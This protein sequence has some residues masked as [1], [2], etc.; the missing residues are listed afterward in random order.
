MNH[1]TSTAATST[2][3]ER[4]VPRE[5]FPS[6]SIAG[7]P[8]CTVASPARRRAVPYA[9]PGLVVALGAGAL[10]WHGPIAQTAHYHEF[11][12][13]RTL[14]GIAHAA[15]VLSN[16]GFALVGI[17]GLQRLRAHGSSPV[18]QAGR[19]G[20]LVFFLALL[21]TS[22]GS[23]FYHLAPD[24]A[25]LVW[26]RLPIAMA[27]AGLLAACWRET[28]GAGRWVTPALVALALASVAWWR[29]TDLQ[30]AG[31]LRPYLLLQFLPMVLLPL[32]QWQH[33]AP[34]AERLATGGAMALYLLAKL[35]ELA[36]HAIFHG[37]V[38]ISGHTI[39]HLLA[40]LAAA[41]LAGALG[42]RLERAASQAALAANAQAA[43]A[44]TPPVPAP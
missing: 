43:Q 25:R 6:L 20:W 8:W 13:Q 15:D 12:D 2:A 22:L 17:W 3:A 19:D 29:F 7:S 27:C 40:T 11:A 32:L 28:I 35:C 44:R 18:L 39:K 30:S 38:V 21:L 42:G 31:D 9:L 33:E 34:M 16:L 10:L 5:P 4:A 26:D 1:S 41:L 37:L 14:L 36:D 23:A 24:N